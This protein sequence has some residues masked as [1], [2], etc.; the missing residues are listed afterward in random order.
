MQPLEKIYR[1][2]N[3]NDNHK[4]LLQLIGSLGLKGKQR[5]NYKYHL[6]KVNIGKVA[7]KLF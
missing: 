6:Y 5:K 7:E 4:T 3:L 1:E 2:M